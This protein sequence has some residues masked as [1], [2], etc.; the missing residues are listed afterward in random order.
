[1]VLAV[2]CGGADVDG[3]F[4]QA[5]HLVQEPVVGVDGDGVGVDHAEV[6]VDDDAGLGAYPVPDPA[7]LQR[8]DVV[9]AGRVAQCRFGGVTSS[10]STASMSLR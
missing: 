9:H 7:Q 5:W 6:V 3:R 2:R 4:G 8:F 10:G 1:M